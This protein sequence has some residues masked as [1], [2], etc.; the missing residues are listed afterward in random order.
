MHPDTHVVG[1]FFFIS[2]PA[3]I[4]GS[5]DA[6]RICDNDGGRCAGRQV[7]NA[8]VGSLG[9]LRKGFRLR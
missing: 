3:Q 4:F 8:S 5:D 1:A 9:A 6:P 7:E 2:K